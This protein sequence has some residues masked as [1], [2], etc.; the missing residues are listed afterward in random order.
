MDQMHLIEQAVTLAREEHESHRDA[1]GGPLLEHLT[2]V[3]G[4]LREQGGTPEA[5]A[6]CWL[7]HILRD[8]DIESEDLR[9]MGF[10]DSIIEA[11]EV[12]TPQPEL[13]EEEWLQR[14]NAHDL[15]RQVKQADIA[16]HTRPEALDALDSA[17]RAHAEEFRERAAEMF[18]R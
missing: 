12:L 8:T 14:I 17:Q 4:E 1:A 15:A 13:S 9:E 11:V 5:I 2:R 16:D 10:S 18:A 3:S 6:V 7:H